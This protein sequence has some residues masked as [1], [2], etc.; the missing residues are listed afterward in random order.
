[1]QNAEVNQ[2]PASTTKKYIS[3]RLLLLNSSF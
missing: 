2:I 1:M 3:K